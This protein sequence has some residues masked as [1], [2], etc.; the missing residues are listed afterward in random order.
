MYNPDTPGQDDCL[1]WRGLPMVLS[2]PAVLRGRRLDS[3]L[4]QMF[5]EPC[6]F[7]AL[8]QPR[9]LQF[10]QQLAEEYLTRLAEFMDFDSWFR[11]L[12]WVSR[13]EEER[14]E[15]NTKPLVTL[16]PEKLEFMAQEVSAQISEV[17]A[18]VRQRR[19]AMNIF[20]W[21][22]VLEAMLYG[23]AIIA[24]VRKSPLRKRLPRKAFVALWEATEKLKPEI[25][26]KT[27]YYAAWLDLRAAM[28]P[29]K[30]PIAEGAKPKVCCVRCGESIDD[31]WDLQDNRHSVLCTNC[32]PATWCSRCN[33]AMRN[34]ASTGGGAGM[35]FLI[36]RCLQCGAHR[37]L[38]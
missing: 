29:Q 35:V 36:F 6:D 26:V 20:E 1:F 2:Q 25:P 18:D 21:S 12:P 13:Q 5:T 11:R 38:K 19:G 22:G 27:P 3:L 8:K 4:S 28:G 14:R 24:E 15:Q 37:S 17:P 9:S 16:T 30:K 34:I 32:A 31:Y 10:D 33:V 23:I 7:M